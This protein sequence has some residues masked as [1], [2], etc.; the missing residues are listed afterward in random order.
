MLT[1]TLR[2]VDL[3]LETYCEMNK[4]YC[5]KSKNRL[6]WTYDKR[7]KHK[8]A[9]NSRHTLHQLNTIICLHEI[10][11]DLQACANEETSTASREGQSNFRQAARRL[12]DSVTTYS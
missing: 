4:L 1:E 5:K 3:N 11:R 8:N 9:F 2:L 12:I 6:R 7:D 10:A